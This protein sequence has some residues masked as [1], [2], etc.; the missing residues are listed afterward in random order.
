MSNVA[1][2]NT[3]A[4]RFDV[5]GFLGA[6]TASSAVIVFIVALRVGN[7]P[8]VASSLC[9]PPTPPISPYLTSAQY[10]AKTTV[11]ISLIFAATTLQVY[12]SRLQRG[13]VWSPG[14][15]S[16]AYS[17][18]EF[19]VNSTGGEHNMST[20]QYKPHAPTQPA[21]SFA[22]LFPRACALKHII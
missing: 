14:I 4:S 21:F 10:I 6:A 11:N 18:D 20:S 3:V 17:M 9:P 7:P 19:E 13:G 2:A 5:G 8:S 16:D 12:K 1:A 22:D 15:N